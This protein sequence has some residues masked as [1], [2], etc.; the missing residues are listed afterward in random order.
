MAA[1]QGAREFLSASPEASEALG[2]YVESVG[3]L[4]ADPDILW[5]TAEKK[6]VRAW[7]RDLEAVRL[8]EIDDVPVQ[9]LAHLLHGLRLIDSNAGRLQ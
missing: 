2:H 7:L 5:T 4:L 1:E 3:F 6:K 9:H 8:S